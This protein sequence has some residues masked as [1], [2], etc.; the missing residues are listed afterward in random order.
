ME[1]DIVKADSKIAQLPSVPSAL[2]DLLVFLPPCFS[3]NIFFFLSLNKK[4]WP[5]KVRALLVIGHLLVNVAYTATSLYV[6]HLNYPGGVA[7]RRLHELV[8]PQT[9]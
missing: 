9:G 3:L 7:M 5:Y 1:Q 6:S 2:K 8:P 4:S